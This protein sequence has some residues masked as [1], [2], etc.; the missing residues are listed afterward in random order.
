MKT[1]EMTNKKDER[2]CGRPPK[3]RRESF[4]GSEFVFKYPDKLFEPVKQRTQ[5]R[6]KLSCSGVGVT[7]KFTRGCR[8]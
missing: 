7:L 4:S 5:E 8:P 1:V 2:L 3:S 6:E